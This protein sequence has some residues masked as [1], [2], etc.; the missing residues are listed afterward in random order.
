MTSLIF[1]EIFF[2]F[3]FSSP[4]SSSS[5]PPP[6]PSSAWYSIATMAFIQYLAIWPIRHFFMPCQIRT[7]RSRYLILLPYSSFFFFFS[8]LKTFSSLS[9]YKKKEDF[10]IYWNQ[11]CHNCVI[12]FIKNS[13]VPSSFFNYLRGRCSRL[14]ETP[15]TSCH[16]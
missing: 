1:V 13:F 15:T 3:S 6:P 16:L 12:D 4:S 8:I 5:S 9:R 10:Y 2:F 7:L 14:A 11:K